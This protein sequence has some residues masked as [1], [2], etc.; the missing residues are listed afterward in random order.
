MV[1]AAV[2]GAELD[3]ALAVGGELISPPF[4]TGSF[5]LK[6]SWEGRLLIKFHLDECGLI[7]CDLARD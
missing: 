5:R 1:D 2:A 4:S 6:Q 7:V 3:P